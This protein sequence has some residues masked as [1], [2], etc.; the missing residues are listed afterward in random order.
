MSGHGFLELTRTAQ[1]TRHR[2]A[3]GPQEEYAQASALRDS[4]TAQ[5]LP[6]A[7]PV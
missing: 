3:Q 1:A 6:G 5:H 2:A 7:P 4:A